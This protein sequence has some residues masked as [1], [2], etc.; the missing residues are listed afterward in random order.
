MPTLALRLPFPTTPRRAA[1]GPLSLAAALTAAAVLLAACGPK[2]D[3]AAQQPPPPEVAVVVVAPATVK[4]TTELPGR[5]E[6]SRVAQVRARAAGILQKRLFEEGSDVK[7]GQALFAID[8]AP[9]QAA[10]Q[11]AQATL[12][13]AQANLSQA[14]ALARRYQPLVQANAVSQQEY[15][16]AV[17]AEQAAQAQVQAGHAAVKTARINLEYASV[18]APISGRIGRALVTEGALVG[19]GEATQLAVVQQIDPLYINLTQS[20]NEVLKLRQALQEGQ[21]RR[22]PGAEAAQVK[23]LLDDG[24]PFDSTGKLLFSD[25]TV[26][27]NT[28]QVSLRAELPNPQSLLLPGM[29]VRVQLELAEV[30]HAI[31]LPQQAVTRGSHGDIAMVVAADG[32]VSPR[33][34]KIAGAQGNHWIVTD[35]LAAGEQVL[36][37]GLMKVAMGTKVVKPVPWQPGKPPAAAGSPGTSASSAA[38]AAP[39]ALASTAASR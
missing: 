17:A 26:D 21:L 38:S 19:Q 35:G 3:D 34:V 11:S 30:P 20:A 29:Y 27:Q 24:T 39:K 33:P 14:A 6:A 4:L 12:A 9:Y 16:N 7:A 25:L 23:V 31:L 10:L 22:A 2:E 13:Q 15:A 32:S 8:P 5:L 18:A 28:G 37:E 36:V 1:R